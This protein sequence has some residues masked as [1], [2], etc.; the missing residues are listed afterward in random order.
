MN[1][2]S[3][4]EY[5]LQSHNG[6]NVFLTG[7]EIY[8]FQDADEVGTVPPGRIIGVGDQQ[9][10]VLEHGSETT[11]LWGYMGSSIV[12]ELTS[13]RPPDDEGF[14]QII[15]QP[16]NYLLNILNRSTYTRINIP[17]EYIIPHTVKY[18]AENGERPK[19]FP[20]QNISLLTIDLYKR[21]RQI[22]PRVNH[23][24]W[25]MTPT[26][27]ISFTKEALTASMDTLLK[28]NELCFVRTDERIGWA[29][30]VKA[31]YYMHPFLVIKS[32]YKHYERLN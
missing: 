11:A 29:P 12:S 32:N 17:S 8:T 26:C 24:W 7:D 15:C 20:Q 25:L 2:F 18:I 19:R 1:C 6:A 10:V 5:K 23:D 16:L 30:P 28:F 31:S 21:Y 22:L 14:K 9:Y 4:D 27:G 13:Q 3:Y